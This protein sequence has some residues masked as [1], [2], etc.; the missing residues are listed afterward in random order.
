[1]A[2]TNHWRSHIEA[3]QGSGLTQSAYCRQHQLHSRT[4]TARLSEYRRERGEEKPVL[5]PVMVTQSDEITPKAKKIVL[6]CAQ[7]H[8]L[9]LPETVSAQWLSAL[10]RGTGL[11][12]EP[13]HIWLAVAPVDMRRGIDGLSMIVQEALGQAACQGWR[14]YSGT[15]RGTGCVYWYGMAMEYGCAS[16]VCTE[17]V[18]FGR[19]WKMP[20]LVLAGNNGSGWCRGWISNGYRGCRIPIGRF[21]RAAEM[22]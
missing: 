19:S 20:V 10:L 1:M 6:H 17:A 16:G 18:L 8:R 2:V 7:G 15:R 13:E 3:W 9:E 14:L 21:E 4:F 22:G 12:G 11:I 5:I